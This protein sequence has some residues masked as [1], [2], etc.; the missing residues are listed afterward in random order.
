MFSFYTFF[1]LK[2]KNLPPRIYLFNQ[3]TSSQVK[4]WSNSSLT[5]SLIPLPFLALFIFIAFWP[6]KFAIFKCGGSLNLFLASA[7]RIPKI[8]AS[9]VSTKALNP[10]F[11]ALFTKSIVT[12]LKHY[13]ELLT[14][15]LYTFY[16][17]TTLG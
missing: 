2:T 1:S 4:D 6:S 3:L 15:V 10:H 17:I 11:S 16:A 7:C 8:G 12:F 5:Y 13:S 14:S 9:T